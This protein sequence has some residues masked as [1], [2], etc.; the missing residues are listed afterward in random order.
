MLFVSWGELVDARGRLLG[1]Q[2]GALAL[3][4]CFPL[5]AKLWAHLPAPAWRPSPLSCWGWWPLPRWHT[6]LLPSGVLPDAEAGSGAEAAAVAFLLEAELCPSTKATLFNWEGSLP[7]TL[8]SL[9]TP[10]SKECCLMFLIPLSFSVENPFCCPPL[11][12]PITL[13]SEGQKVSFSHVYPSPPVVGAYTHFLFSLLGWIPPWEVTGPQASA[14]SPSWVHTQS[15]R[16]VCARS[17]S[18]SRFCLPR[19]P[20]SSLR[21][22]L[23][24]W[25]CG[26]PSGVI[27]TAVTLSS[28]PG[29]STERTENIWCRFKVYIQSEERIMNLPKKSFEPPAVPPRVNILCSKACPC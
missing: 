16:S 4:D 14:L 28:H 5:P 3:G 20:P 1:L 6:S 27:D 13:R 15:T 26:G 2:N 21:L 18:P 29:A 10:V 24:A 8:C 11:R 19:L 25:Q 9:L 7:P 17:L 22:N 12:D 23:H